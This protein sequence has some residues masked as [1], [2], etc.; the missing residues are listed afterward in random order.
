MRAACLDHLF[1][2]Q[3]WTHHLLLNI[4]GRMDHVLNIQGRMDHL[5]NIQ[6][7]MDHLLF[8]VC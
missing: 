5:L 1:N 2:I 6:G 8:N 7:W 3:G 4:Q